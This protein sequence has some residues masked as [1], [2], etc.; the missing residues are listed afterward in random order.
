MNLSQRN[1]RDHQRAPALRADG[2]RDII[3]SEQGIGAD[4][5]DH[6]TGELPSI[7]PGRTRSG[8]GDDRSAR[9]GEIDGEPSAFSGIFWRDGRDSI[10]LGAMLAASEA[11][12]YLL[13]QVKTAHII[14]VQAAFTLPPGI[15]SLLPDESSTIREA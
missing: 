8:G 2:S 11:K 12:S 10:A 14:A 5:A 7:I 9:K 3:K 1:L 4:E 15:T 13:V 6:F